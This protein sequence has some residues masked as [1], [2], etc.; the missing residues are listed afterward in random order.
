MNVLQLFVATKEISKL[1]L[2]FCG[3][4]CTK[5]YLDSELENNGVECIAALPMHLYHTLFAYGSSDHN[6]RVWHFQ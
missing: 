5:F 2:D 3:Y 4:H 6:L 1:V